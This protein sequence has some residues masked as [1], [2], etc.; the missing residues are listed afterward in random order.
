MSTKRFSAPPGR[1]KKPANEKRSI[2][3][4]VR[5]S[6]DE[7]KTLSHRA[8]SVGMAIAPYMRKMALAGWVQRKDLMLEVDETLQMLAPL[9]QRLLNSARFEEALELEKAIHK[10][11]AILPKL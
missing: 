7:A 11:H 8:G 5:I 10:L 1:K 6:P 3:R 9:R 4:E 2:R